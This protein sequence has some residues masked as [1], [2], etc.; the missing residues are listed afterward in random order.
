MVT[1]K[2]RPIGVKTPLGEDVLLLR[3]MTGTEHL[4]RLSQYELTALSTDESIKMDDI[5]GQNITV[6]VDMVAPQLSRMRAAVSADAPSSLMLTPAIEI[7]AGVSVTVEAPMTKETTFSPSN[8]AGNA[9][10]A[11]GEGYVRCSYAAGMAQ[12]EEALR[13]MSAFMER[14][15][16]E[17]AA[18]VGSASAKA[19]EPLGVT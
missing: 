3:S 7:E 4:G 13:R 8:V 18:A 2:T 19:A 11:C 5:L 9:F 15:R 6:R 10:G 12:L 16:R 17:L 1:Q 14:R